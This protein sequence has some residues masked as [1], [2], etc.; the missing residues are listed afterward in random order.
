MITAKVTDKIQKLDQKLLH[1][2]LRKKGCRYPML[3]MINDIKA[4]GI[5]MPFA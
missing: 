5:C 4:D 1:K 2:D 3:K